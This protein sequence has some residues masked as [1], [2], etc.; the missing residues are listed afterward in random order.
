VDDSDLQ[1]RRRT[2]EFFV[3]QGRAP[4]AAELGDPEQVLSALDGRLSPDWIPHTRE[5][6][7]AILERLGLSGDFCRLA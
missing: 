1:L 7:Q 2:Y 4:V 5:Q 6:N 3:E